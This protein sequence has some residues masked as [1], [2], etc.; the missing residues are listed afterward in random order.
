MAPCLKPSTPIADNGLKVRSKPCAMSA[1]HHPAPPFQPLEHPLRDLDAW[2]SYY[3]GADIPIFADT[4]DALEAMRANEDDVDANLIGEMVARDP[5]MTLKIMA[6]VSTHRPERLITDIETVTGAVVLLGISPFFA[7]FGPQL[8]VEDR[9]ADRPEAQQGLNQVL[10]RAHR[11]AQF[12]LAF[13]IHRMDHDA[14]IIHQA[15]LLHDFA[16]MLMWCHAPALAQ[17]VSQ[18]QHDDPTLRSAAAQLDVYHVRLIELQQALMRA[19]RLP[20]LV[21]RINDDLHADHPSVRNVVLA[22]RLA[23]HTSEGWDNPA[24]PDDVAEIAELLTMS[25][26]AT[27]PYL[28]GLEI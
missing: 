5:L 17:Q 11:A 14:A 22:I 9:L 15:A 21:I 7:T 12:A 27:L 23:R 24:V 6:Y 18:A 20:E 8:T 19:W 28:Q 26:E 25:P 2:V 16:E 13:A 1:A 4:A 3:R 10:R